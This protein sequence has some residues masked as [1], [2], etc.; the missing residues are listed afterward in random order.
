MRG[1]YG[2]SAP[3]KSC[4]FLV[5]C[6]FFFFYM[7]DHRARS[8]S[9]RERRGGRG[10]GGGERRRGDEEER[11]AL[12]VGV[13]LTEPTVVSWHNPVT[14]PSSVFLLFSPFTIFQLAPDLFFLSSFFFFSI[15]ASLKSESRVWRDSACCSHLWWLPFS[16]QSEQPALCCRCEWLY[17]PFL[18]KKHFENSGKDVTC[19]WASPGVDL[20]FMWW[21]W[22]IWGCS[23]SLAFIWRSVSC[24]TAVCVSFIRFF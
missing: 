20:S 12:S 11:K 7:F 1:Q 23:G 13:A 4:Q 8:S 10:E 19:V 18:I 6:C 3:V 9:S 5:R 17:F 15:S 24:S 16:V 22:C 21:G 2:H 14:P